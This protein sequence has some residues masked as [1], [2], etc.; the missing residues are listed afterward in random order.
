MLVPGHASCPWGLLLLK[1]GRGSLSVGGATL[2]C[3][4]LYVQ[5][6]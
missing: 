6:C 1:S 5:R 4:I 2:S 3:A